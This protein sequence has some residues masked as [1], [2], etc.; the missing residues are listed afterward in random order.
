MLVAVECQD[1]LQGIM[2]VLRAPRRSKVT[3]E[4]I[5]YVDYLESAPWNLKTPAALPRFI[6]VGTVL[7]AEAVRLGLEMNLDGRVGLHSL[8]Q[9]ETF[10]ETR[11]RMTRFSQDAE[12]FNLTY[13]EFV[14]QQATEWLT[15]IGGFQ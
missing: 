1:D 15:S 8:P 5:I 14:G 3:D 13:F 11:C 10:Y 7:I 12:Y 4:P 6:G 2:A 9:A